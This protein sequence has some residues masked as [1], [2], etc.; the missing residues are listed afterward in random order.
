MNEFALFGSYSNKIVVPIARMFHSP[1]SD[2][3]RLAFVSLHLFFP[4]V[5]FCDI[6]KPDSFLH[7]I[8]WLPLASCLSLLLANWS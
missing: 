4:H 6:K 2:N 5:S 1:C 8:M 7:N 3:R